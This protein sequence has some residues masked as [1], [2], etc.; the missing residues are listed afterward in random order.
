V[1]LTP[2]EAA[3]LYRTGMSACEIAHA[4]RITR[5]GARPGSAAVAWPASGGEASDRKEIPGGCRAGRYLL[6][7]TLSALCLPASAN[8]S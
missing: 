6:I 3:A 1:S 5:Q 4:C 2:A 8:V 7:T